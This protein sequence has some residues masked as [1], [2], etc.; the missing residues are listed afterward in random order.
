[1][2]KK[3]SVTLCVAS[4]FGFGITSAQGETVANNVSLTQTFT[5]DFQAEVKSGTCSFSVSSPG[6]SMDAAGVLDVDLGTIRKDGETKGSLKPLNFNLTAC[7]DAIFTSVSVLGN[8]PQT[9]VTEKQGHISFYADDAG[10][11]PW[12]P[13][14]DE[15][16]W[17]KATDIG[18]QTNVTQTKYVRFEQIAETGLGTHTGQII[19]T[20]TYQ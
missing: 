9:I 8:K 2:L 15:I 16:Y 18:S 3:L 19:F 12:D 6:A 17:D 4:A 14:T 10:N 5:V 20:A 1:M 13:S 7:S 11:S